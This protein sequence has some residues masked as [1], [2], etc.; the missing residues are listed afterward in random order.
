MGGGQRDAEADPTPP[1]GRDHPI[2]LGE[3]RGNRLL[4]VDMGTGIDRREHHLLVAVHVPRRHNDD[5]GA[6]GA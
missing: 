2:C 1:G 4:A 5:V 6:L 3:R